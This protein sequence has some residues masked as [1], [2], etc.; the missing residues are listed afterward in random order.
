MGEDGPVTRW[1]KEVK[2]AKGQGNMR[3]KGQKY[4]KTG[5]K[6]QADRKTGGKETE[7]QDITTGQQE[8][9]TTVRQTY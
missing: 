3:T 1:V 2:R 6:G 4:R 9:R 7:K 5:T 8:Y